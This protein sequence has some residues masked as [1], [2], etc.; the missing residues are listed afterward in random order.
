M[1]KDLP[2]IELFMLQVIYDLSV[3]TKENTYEIN[4]N[5]KAAFIDFLRSKF[6]YIVP[7]LVFKWNNDLEFVFVIVVLINS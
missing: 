3:T 2:R 5:I 4:N 6:C 7:S 1:A